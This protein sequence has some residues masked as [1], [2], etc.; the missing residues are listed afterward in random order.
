MKREL[1]G[2]IVHPKDFSEVLAKFNIPIGKQDVWLIRWGII[3]GIGLLA[4]VCFYVAL[5]SGWITHFELLM[6]S[7]AVPLWVGVYIFFPVTI[8]NVFNRLWNEGVIGPSCG[9]S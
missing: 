9:D 1:S 8:A 4:V 2:E 6:G 5:A 7:L 3:I